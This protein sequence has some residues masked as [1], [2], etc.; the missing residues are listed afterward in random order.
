MKK[1]V[2]K[3]M[4]QLLSHRQERRALTIAV[5][6]TVAPRV[7]VVVNAEISVATNTTMVKWNRRLVTIGPVV[8]KNQNTTCVP[9]RPYGKVVKRR[10]RNAAKNHPPQRQE[11]APRIV[12]RPTR[13][14][15]N[16]G[17]ANAR[18]VVVIDTTR[19]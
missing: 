8:S 18:K 13:A 2:T 7:W 11:N 15:K 9:N 19:A 1:P 16:R 3:K 6:T 12:V 14:P 5:R 10:A 4:N 17:V